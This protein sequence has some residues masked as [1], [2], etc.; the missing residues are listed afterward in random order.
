VCGYVFVFVCVGMCEYVCVSVWVCVCVCMCE[1]VCVGVWV[2]VWGWMFVFVCVGQRSNP[3]C[4][5]QSLLTLF[6][7]II[8]GFHLT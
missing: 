4:F 3:R 8:S 7:Q 6:S 2:C 1:Y 5:P